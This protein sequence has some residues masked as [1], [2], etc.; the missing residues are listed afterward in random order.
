MNTY[1]TTNSCRLRNHDFTRVTTLQNIDLHGCIMCNT[2]MKNE[3]QSK[4][5]CLYLERVFFTCSMD[6]HSWLKH[7]KPCLSNFIHELSMIRDDFLWTAFQ[8]F[9]HFIK[10]L[11]FRVWKAVFI[12]RYTSIVLSI[13]R[14]SQYLFRKFFFCGENL[15]VFFISAV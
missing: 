1:R 3:S 9:E 2:W 5:N 15:E 7:H 10:I 8:W 12:N 13:N 4:R 11:D 6:W 14:F